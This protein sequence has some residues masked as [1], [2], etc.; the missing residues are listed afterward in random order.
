MN[1]PTLKTKKVKCYQEIMLGAIPSVYGNK[2]FV[3]RFICGY[4]KCKFQIEDGG[5]SYDHIGSRDNYSVH[6]DNLQEVDASPEWIELYQKQTSKIEWDKIKLGRVLS[7]TNQ[8]VNATIPTQDALDERNYR[9]R[10]DGIIIDTIRLINEKVI[11]IDSSTAPGFDTA[12]NE[13]KTEID[14]NGKISIKGLEMNQY[15][16]ILMLSHFPIYEKMRKKVIDKEFA[17]QVLN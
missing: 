13:I 8:I 2:V 1:L 7:L 4:K 17:F 14:A 9:T 3:A 6:I 11:K 10:T 5:C 15:I 16:S 12:I